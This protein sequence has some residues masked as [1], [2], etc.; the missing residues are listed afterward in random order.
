[1]RGL[2]WS[3]SAHAKD[4]WT[5]EPW[6]VTEKLADCSWLVT[7]TA[8]GLQRLRELAP[9]AGTAAARLSRPRLRAICRRRRAARPRR[10]GANAADPVVILSIGRKVEKKG[11]GDL[12]EALARLPTALHWRFEHVGAGELSDALK[13]QAA[14]ARHRRALHLA[15]RP[16]AEGGVRRPGARR[17]VRAGEQ[18]GGRRRPGRPAQRADGGGP[19]GPRHRLDPRRRD[20]RI[21][22]RRRQRTAGGARRARRTGGGARPPGGRSRPAPAP[23][24]AAPARSCARAFPSRPASTGSRRRSDQRGLMPEARAAE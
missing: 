17:P 19:S 3:V 9:R 18:E 4:I 11:Y 24:A 6:E 16:A 5:S 12:L 2:P 21:H 15:R 8:V 22:H 20:R 1:M 13:A 23:G 7:C 10:D 14:R